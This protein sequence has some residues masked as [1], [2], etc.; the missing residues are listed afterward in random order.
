MRGARSLAT[1]G[2][3]GFSLPETLYGLVM[4]RASTYWTAIVIAAAAGGYAYDQATLALWN[5]HNRGKI[6]EDMIKT[7][8]EKPPEEEEEEE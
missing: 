8:P 5:A 6:F 7:F 2:G 3:K 4:K 1:V